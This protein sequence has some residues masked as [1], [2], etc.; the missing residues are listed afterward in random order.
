MTLIF[1]CFFV[2]VLLNFVVIPHF[3][4]CCCFA[5]ADVVFPIYFSSHNVTFLFF[6]GLSLL[7]SLEIFCC[8]GIYV[9]GLVS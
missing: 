8:V 7:K 2:V 5:A 9:V 6:S 4:H 3:Q 1:E